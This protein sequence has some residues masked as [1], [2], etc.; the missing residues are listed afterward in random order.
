MGYIEIQSRR[1][2]KEIIHSHLLY[3]SADKDDEL[4]GFHVGDLFTLSLD[5]VLQ[6]AEQLKSKKI[7]GIAIQEKDILLPE[8]TPKRYIV[9]IEFRIVNRSHLILRDWMTD[10]KGFRSTGTLI[11][12]E[13][14][15]DEAEEMFL[16]LQ[17]AFENESGDLSK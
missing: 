15:S 1:D 6:R 3:D 8:I 2:E 4:S 5:I 13:A 7:V 16:E 11:S 9:E 12:I 10:N 17:N 14:I